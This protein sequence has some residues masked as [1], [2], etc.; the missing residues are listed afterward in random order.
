MAKSEVRDIPVKHIHPNPDNPRWEAGDV[1][2]LSKS[3]GEDDLLQTLLVTPA[4]QFGEGH[5]MILDGYRRWVAA[6]GAEGTLPCMVRD[7]EPDEDP[8]LAALV[9]GL[10]T[11]EHKTHLTAVERAKGYGRLR[12]EFGMTQEQIAARF[13]LT[14]GTIGRYLSL[15]ELS[16][17]SQKAVRD[18]RLSVENAIKAVQGNRAKNRKKEGKKPIDVGWEPDHFSEHHILA[19]KAKVMCDEMGHSTRRRYGGACHACWEVVI[20]ADQTRLNHAMRLSDSVPFIPPVPITP[21]GAIRAN[22]VTGA[23]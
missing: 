8:V 15:L 20:R 1:T 19:K 17:K 2:G 9:T 10:A 4:P 14:P 13:G 5:V 12:D 16:D 22:G 18:G 6:K 11:D 21:D 7:L 3:I 23:Q